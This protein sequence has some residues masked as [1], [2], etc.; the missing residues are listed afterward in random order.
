M[1]WALSTGTYMVQMT[2]EDEAGDSVTR[3]IEVPFDTNIA[4]TTGNI[5]AILDDWK[6]ATAGQ[7][8]TASVTLYYIDDAPKTPVVGAEVEGQA[9]ISVSLNSTL[10]N[11][12][13][14]PATISVPAPEIAMFVAASGPSKNVVDVSD[15]LVTG[16]VANYQAGGKATLA[17]G[18]LA[19]NI[20]SGKRVHRRSRKG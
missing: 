3:A 17:N 15:L 8:V 10:P 4:T 1:A 16:L 11:G 19:V 13:P 20:L 9:S 7:I 18:K 5:P 6:A 2:I 12:Q 14:Q